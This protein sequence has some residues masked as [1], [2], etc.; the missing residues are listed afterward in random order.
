MFDYYVLTNV[1]D[2]FHDEDGAPLIADFQAVEQDTP[3]DSE[4]LPQQLNNEPQGLFW[5]K[6]GEGEE[7]LSAGEVYN[8][9]VPQAKAGEFFA[10]FVYDPTTNKVREAKYTDSGVN[11]TLDMV[12]LIALKNTDFVFLED[13]PL[14]GEE[15]DAWRAFRQELRDIMSL[16]KEQRIRMMKREID[17]WPV[18]PDPE[19]AWRDLNGPNPFTPIGIRLMSQFSIFG[20]AERE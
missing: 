20:D 19:I 5:V 17:A 8:K 11:R 6:I 12:R 7:D 9:F 3:T 4:G 13:S 2:N 16:P 18:A 14:S 15:K 10:L 1:A